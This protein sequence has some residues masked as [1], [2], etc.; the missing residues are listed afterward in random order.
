M[1]ILVVGAGGK[2]GKLVVDR[3]LSA[4]HKVVAYLHGSDPQDTDKEKQKKLEHEPH[5]PGVEVVHGDSANP[6]RLEHA[7]EGCEAVIDAIG[8]SKPFLNTDLE[9]SSAKAIIEAMKRVGARRIVAISMLG[10]G[11]SVEQTPWAYEHLLKPTFL[12]GAAKDKAAMEATVEASGLEFV[13]VRPPVLNDHDATGQVEIVG[14]HGTA[15]K[16]TRADLAQFL[17]EQLS[18]SAHVGQTVTVANS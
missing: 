17:V 9:Q 10:V 12:R 4:G 14:E 13:I 16:M 15:H 8:G 6:S 3:A 18:G 2:T 5:W 11:D 1:K 7:M